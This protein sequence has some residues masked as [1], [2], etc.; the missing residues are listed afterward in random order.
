[1]QLVPPAVGADGLMR[2]A[3]TLLHDGSAR[4]PA[5][6]LTAATTALALLGLCAALCAALAPPPAPPLAPPPAQRPASA[7]QEKKQGKAA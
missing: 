2:L 5:A 4:L 7:K 1:M 6:Q 3:R